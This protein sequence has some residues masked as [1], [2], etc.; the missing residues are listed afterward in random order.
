VARSLEEEGIAAMLDYLGE[1]VER[2]EQAAAAADAYVRALKRIEED[3]LALMNKVNIS[4]KLTQLGLD[5][6]TDASLENASRVLEVA[7]SARTLVMIDMESSEYV[8]RTLEC[9]RALRARAPRLGI[10]I[11]ASLRRSAEDVRRLAAEGATVRVCKGAYLEPPGAVFRSRAEVRRSFAR[12]T[13][14][15]LSAGCEVHVATHDERLIEGAK[16][17]LERRGIPRTAAEF[18]MLYGIRQDLQVRL[19]REGHAIRVYLPYGR[20]WYPY[21]SRRLAERPANLW[22]LASNL[23]KGRR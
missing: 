8:D 11:Q 17:F 13:A 16:R 6:S 7:E 5:I 9:F 14:T 2:P 22:F 10:C 3:G 23:V 19:A 21:L 18:Q 4:I 1:N 12:L 20:E 15:L